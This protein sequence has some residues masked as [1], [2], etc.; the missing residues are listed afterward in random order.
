VAEFVIVLT[1]GPPAIRVLLLVPVAAVFG[2]CA[3]FLRR[4][5]LVARQARIARPPRR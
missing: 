3:W 2:V 5:F 4:R 1:V